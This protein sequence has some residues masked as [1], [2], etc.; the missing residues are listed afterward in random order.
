MLAHMIKILSHLL[1]CSFSRA[2]VKTFLSFRI[3]MAESQL[4]LEIWDWSTELIQEEELTLKPNLCLLWTNFWVLSVRKQSHLQAWSTTEYSLS[5]VRL[6]S[7]PN[8]II[9]SFLHTQKPIASTK[10]ISMLWRERTRSTFLTSSCRR[11]K[12][13]K[14]SANSLDKFNC[15]KNKQVTRLL[16]WS[17]WE[18]LFYFN[19]LMENLS[20]WIPP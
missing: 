15:P 19:S 13:S 18:V 1:T 6:V 12:S 9:A 20:S 11:S 17:L 10:T 5:H 3:Q 2:R 8:Q 4:W 14:T 7:M 16:A